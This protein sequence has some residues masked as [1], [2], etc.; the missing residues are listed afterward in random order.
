MDTESAI[1]MGMENRWKTLRVFDWNKCAK[2]ICENKPNEVVAGL[3]KDLEYTS[4][5]IW[6]D[7][8]VEDDYTYLSSTWAIPVMI[9]DDGEEI[10]CWLWEY[11]TEWRAGTKWPESA[12]IIIAETFGKKRE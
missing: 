12:Q 4:G 7:G 2:Y 6:E 9:A 3:S 11:E 1:L 5:V 8:I 10:E